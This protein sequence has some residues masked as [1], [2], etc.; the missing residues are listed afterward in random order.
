MS[1]SLHAPVILLLII[2]VVN[3]HPTEEPKEIVPLPGCEKTIAEE[4]E[5]PP[6]GWCNSYARIITRFNEMMSNNLFGDS[7][8][9]S[10]P[11][12]DLIEMC[13][14]YDICHPA[15]TS[16]CWLPELIPEKTISCGYRQLFESSYAN[17]IRKAHETRSKCDA[18]NDFATNFT[19]EGLKR[20]CKYFENSEDGNK[21]KYAIYNQCGHR[22]INQ[23]HFYK[24]T[25]MDM[26]NCSS[27]L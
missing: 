27:T 21:V 12:H 4:F 10:Y 16:R 22:A 1:R 17:C 15:T 11:Y 5:D 14:K 26:Y 20:K 7:V 13:T 9:M 3:G 6:I 18:F 8:T 23:F 19:S 24:K 2:L 25:L